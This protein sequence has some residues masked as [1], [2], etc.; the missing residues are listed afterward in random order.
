MRTPP[1]TMVCIDINTIIAW[2]RNVCNTYAQKN[3]TG[4][5]P[6]P[7]AVDLFGLVSQFLLYKIS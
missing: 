6:Y 5:I 3:R 1:M 4:S 7:V 2:M